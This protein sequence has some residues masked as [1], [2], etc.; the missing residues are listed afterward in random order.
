MRTLDPTSAIPTRIPRPTF[1][2]ASPRTPSI[3]AV[4]YSAMN[5]VNNISTATGSHSQSS[6]PSQ[7]SPKSSSLT[8]AVPSDLSAQ[9]IKHG[10]RIANLEDIPRTGSMQSPGHRA[11][12]SAASAVTMTQS[13]YQRMRDRS[14]GGPVRA[15]VHSVV[16]VETQVYAP[17]DGDSSVTDE[18]LHP[19]SARGALLEPAADILE[20]PMTPTPFSVL[21]KVSETSEIHDEDDGKQHRDTKKPSSASHHLAITVQPAVIYASQNS[22]PATQLE[23]CSDRDIAAKRTVLNWGAQSKP[24]RRD[25][26]GR[27][28]SRLHPLYRTSASNHGEA[29]RPLYTAIPVNIATSSSMQAE[30]G[31]SDGGTV[32]DSPVPEGISILSSADLTETAPRVGPTT[33]QSDI[34]DLESLRRGPRLRHT[35]MPPNPSMAVNAGRGVPG[36]TKKLWT[37]LGR[38]RRMMLT[39]AIL[40]ESS[41]LNAVASVTA[42]V[43]IQIEH[44]YA[45][46]GLVAWAALSAAFVVAF[47]VLL[48]F[49]F[50]QYRKMNNDVVSGESWIEMHVRSRPLPPP[51]QGQ[52]QGQGGEHSKQEENGAT[53]AWQKFIQDHEQLRRYVEFLESR[54]GVLEEGRPNPGQQYY[55]DESNTAD[56]AGAGKNA[57]RGNTVNRISQTPRAST[58]LAAP[59]D[60]NTSKPKKLVSASGSMSHRQLLQPEDAASGPSESWQQGSDSDGSGAIPKSDTKVSILTEL[61]EAVTEGYS[62]LSEHMPRGSSHLSQNLD[63]HTT[64]SAG[65]SRNSTLSPLGPGVRSADVL[66]GKGENI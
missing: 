60:D 64:P 66:K 57:A 30:H 53:E 55:N 63:T 49:A 28:V 44:G 14:S 32:T 3:R 21:L 42:V 43:V 19:S 39:S 5:R 31:S 16:S 2:A 17:R 46:L 4:R 27:V 33:L 58:T 15:D 41:L 59:G 6:W 10:D 18:H 9:G 11:T 20:R 26:E 45:G 36:D 1:M 54:I 8:N 34:Q 35:R 56:E 12:A 65:R 61:C 62:P 38:S 25:E 29:R 7:K 52:G 50:L 37:S 13:L 40:L 51:P 24:L 22:E 23:S 48:A 47:G